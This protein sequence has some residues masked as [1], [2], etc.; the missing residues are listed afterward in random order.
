MT[1][2]INSIYKSFPT[3]KACADLLEK[4]RWGGTP[5]CPHCKKSYYTP[6]PKQRKYHCNICNSSFSVTCTT[7]L[8][9]TKIDI[10]KWFYVILFLSSNEKKISLRDLAKEISVTKDTALRLSNKVKQSF[11]SESVFINQ[12][13]NLLHD[14]KE[15][16]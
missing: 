4:A 11:I 6:L 14:G 12:I 1:I 7:F 13:L 9:K 10:Q 8:H 5:V 2:K 3:Q 15:N 16:T